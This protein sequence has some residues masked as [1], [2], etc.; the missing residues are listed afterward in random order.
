[1]GEIRELKE[2]MKF[3]NGV[4]LKVL[5]AVNGLKEQGEPV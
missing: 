5:D 1:V 4:Y 3:Q 2:I